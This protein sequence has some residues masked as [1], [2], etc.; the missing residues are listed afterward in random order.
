MLRIQLRI[1][2]FRSIAGKKNVFLA[3]FM[4]LGVALKMTS[5]TLKKKKSCFV[6]LQDRRRGLPCINLTSHFK[7]GCIDHKILPRLVS[8]N[9]SYLLES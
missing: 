2:L 4:E 7:S 8:T 1:K 3:Q 9:N 5:C 6:D